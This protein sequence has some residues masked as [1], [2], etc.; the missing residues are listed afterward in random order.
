MASTGS[1]PS[2]PPPAPSSAPT[3]GGAAPPPHKPHYSLANIAG[4]ATRDGGLTLPALR[5]AA[6]SVARSKCFSTAF[7]WAS[8]LGGLFAAHRFKQGGSLRRATGDGVLAALLTFGAQW[9][10]CRADEV[11]RRAALKA[12]YLQQARKTSGANAP[13]PAEGG[14][15]GGDG[16]GGGGGGGGDDDAAAASRELDRVVRY[17]LPA[18][19][20]GPAT[21]VQIR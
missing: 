3:S 15:D 2:P 17:D 20:R 21:S 4:A 1:A 13:L 9:Y 14:S 12:F 8:G 16:D 6:D 18:V 11:D 7:L 5:A 19:S 10:L